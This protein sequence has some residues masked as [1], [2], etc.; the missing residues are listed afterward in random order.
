M[1]GGGAYLRDTTVIKIGHLFRSSRYIYTQE[2]FGIEICWCT[3]FDGQ[4]YN[5]TPGDISWYI[6]YTWQHFMVHVVH[7]VTFHGTCGTPGDISWYMWYTWRHF[8]V[9]V[10]HLATFH[11]TSGTPGD[12]SWY[13]WYT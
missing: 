5:G 9:H 8:M 2:Y 4:K 10:V 11:G 3:S 12:I 6:W 1:G 7:L 13:I